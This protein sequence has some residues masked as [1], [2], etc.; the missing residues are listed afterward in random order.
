MNTLKIIGT[1]K[2]EKA[3]ENISG[4]PQGKGAGEGE[5]GTPAGNKLVKG[6]EAGDGK[7]TGAKD[8]AKDKEVKSL[9]EGGSSKKEL[10][11]KVEKTGGGSKEG[12]AKDD[13]MGKGDAGGGRDNGSGEKTKGK[14]K[15]G[16]K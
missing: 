2:P 16:V 10:F 1:M 13:G 6:Q 4:P 9:K 8:K 5:E 15:K 14:K 12:K 11:P 7:M 3:S